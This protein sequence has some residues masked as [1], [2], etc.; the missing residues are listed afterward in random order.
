MN[1]LDPS[2][3]RDMCAGITASREVEISISRDGLEYL[4]ELNGKKQVEDQTEKQPSVS[5][6]V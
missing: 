5:G 3:M 2:D 4:G 6:R 1:I